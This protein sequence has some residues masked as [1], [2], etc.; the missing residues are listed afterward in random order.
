MGLKHRTELRDKG[1][2]TTVQIP[3]LC[4][5]CNDAAPALLFKKDGKLLILL[6][7]NEYSSDSAMSEM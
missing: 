5:E 2:Q 4:S 6:G 3:R 7:G 1:K